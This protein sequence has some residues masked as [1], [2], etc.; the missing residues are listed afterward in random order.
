MEGVREKSDDVRRRGAAGRTPGWSAWCAR[1][2]Q[3]VRPA[4]PLQLPHRVSP[5]T[6]GHRRV[7]VH[8]HTSSLGP[9]HRGS[10]GLRAAGWDAGHPGGGHTHQPL[11]WG[12][13]RGPSIDVRVAARVRDILSGAYWRPT[14]DRILA[15][16]VQHPPVPVGMTGLL[17]GC[18]SAARRSLIRRPRSGFLLGSFFAPLRV[19]VSHCLLRY[20]IL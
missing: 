1:R 4:E 18:L 6:R 2:L 7:T 11:R 17:A 16:H 8:L 3:V 14:P 15:G 13:R 12:R 10:L 9:T 20:P 19:R 5:G